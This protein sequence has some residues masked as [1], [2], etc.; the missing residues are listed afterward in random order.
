MINRKKRQKILQLFMEDSDK[1]ALKEL[2]K[3]TNDTLVKILLYVNEKG[4][5][6]DIY[7]YM[8]SYIFDK[9]K[10]DKK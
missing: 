10:L 7:E 4:E 6:Q 9:Y 2:Y 5:K 8:I 3:I 1:V